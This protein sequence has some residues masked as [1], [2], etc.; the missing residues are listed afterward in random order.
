MSTHQHEAWQIR[1][2]SIADY[3]AA[4]GFRVFLCDL[5]GQWRSGGITNV[6]DSMEVILA[7]QTCAPRA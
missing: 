6:G 4:C 5:C 7:C 1:R 3:C 2:D